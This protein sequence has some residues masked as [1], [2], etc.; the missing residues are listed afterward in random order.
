MQVSRTFGDK[1]AKLPRYGGNPKVV[2]SDPDIQHV[3]I[4]ERSDFVFIACNDLRDS[5]CALRGSEL[6]RAACEISRV[7]TRP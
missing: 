4:S 7:S 5:R 2:I 6:N 1:D 3:T